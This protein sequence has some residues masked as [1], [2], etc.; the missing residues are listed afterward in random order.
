MHEEDRVDHPMIVPQSGAALVF[1][2]DWLP[3]IGRRAERSAYRFARRYRATHLVLGNAEAAAV[4]LAMLAPGS[5]RASDILWSAAQCLASLFPSG[6]V[7]I[8]LE[9]VP[10]RFWV[11]AT[12]DGN[13][14]AGTDRFHPGAGPA[15]GAVEEL[16]QAFPR[17]TVLGSPGA[18]PMPALS[19]LS[20]AGT[21]SARLVRLRRRGAVLRVLAWW[22]G[23]GSAAAMPI[24]WLWAPGLPR[25]ASP[26]SRVSDIDPAVAWAQARKAA[27]HGR[28]VHG[29]AGT[30]LVLDSLYELPAIVAGWGLAQASCSPEN[31]GWR[32]RAE[33]QRRASHADS[34]TFLA[35]A[36]GEWRVTFPSL[37]QA[38]VNWRLAAGAVA[39][40]DHV[41]D[42][43]RHH[44]AHMLSRLQALSP[45]FTR[46][47][48]GLPTALPVIPPRDGR[49]RALP[50]PQGVSQHVTRAVRVAGPL[51]SAALLIPVVSSV[52]WAR[53]GVTLGDARPV[54]LTSSRLMVSLE[55]V[56]HA[57]EPPPEV[58]ATSPGVP[59]R[60]A[61][62]VGAPP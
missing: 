35:Q 60:S 52:E 58:G 3:L 1:G 44:D 33:Y 46:L 5:A 17:L 61:S 59:T 4:G 6:T 11:A 8:M 40:A 20:A 28:V 34:G 16:R 51:R 10:G 41:P 2:M 37:D 54:S 50:S 18:P 9:V 24:W 27:K 42:S 25:G 19:A 45:A 7:A 29:Q 13:V 55:G 53:I 39:L 56:V 49:G 12:H 38:S 36:S 31:L 21:E 47:D 23:V 22:L 30:R 62:T 48:L 43:A 15:Q 57:S 14:V 26:A 32:C